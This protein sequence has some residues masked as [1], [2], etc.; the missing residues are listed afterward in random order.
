M[1]RENKGEGKSTMMKAKSIFK[2]FL[3][4]LA[5]FV[6]VAIVFVASSLFWTGLI[7]NPQRFIELSFP[8]ILIGW[9][10]FILFPQ[11]LL[12]IFFGKKVLG[13]KG[14]LITLCV[15][16][17]IMPQGFYF[18]HGTIEG[19]IRENQPGGLVFAFYGIGGWISIIYGLL[20]L[21]S[22]K[23]KRFI[24]FKKI[25]L[26]GFLLHFLLLGSLFAPYL[27]PFFQPID[28]S[29]FTIFNDS[30]LDK[31][32]G[33]ENVSKLGRWDFETGEGG[34]LF[35][36]SYS[37]IILTSLIGIFLSRRNIHQ[38]G[39]NPVSSK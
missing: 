9:I 13:L 15:L 2:K 31:L 34:I 3:L 36:L 14:T 6:S 32:H 19:V 26:L 28:F 29:F 22:S 8:E 5:Y 25:L 10:I 11:V 37:L 27:F 23:I 38:K 17:A 35:L 7:G 20:L 33:I 12:Y 16:S 30:M 24:S 39:A 21:F 1:C 4:V 18:W